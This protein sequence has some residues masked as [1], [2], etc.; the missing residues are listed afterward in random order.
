MPNAADNYMKAL[1][2]IQ[3]KLLNELPTLASRLSMLTDAELTIL[4]R[5]LDFFQELNRLGYS[6]ALST[7]MDQYDNVASDVFAEASKRGLQVSVASAQSLEL[8]K[9]LDAMTLLGRAREYSS[10]LK[11]EMLKGIIAGESGGDIARRLADTIGKELTGANV[12]MIVND[13]FARF[14]NSAT[15]KAFEDDSTAKFRYIGPLDEV[16]RQECQDVLAKQ[17][18]SGYTVDEIGGLEVGLS[19]RGGFNCRHDWVAV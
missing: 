12:N 18:E 7:L 9:E 16:T 2:V 8:V 4:A 3:A 1:D 10:K 14:S 11:T 13:S 15:F 6:D 19:D 17:P 5:E